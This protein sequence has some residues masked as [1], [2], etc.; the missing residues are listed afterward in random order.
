MPG[1]V[2]WHGLGRH[3]LGGPVEIEFSVDLPR[4]Q[5]RRPLMLKVDG[6]RSIGVILGDPAAEDSSAIGNA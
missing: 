1:K 5:E 6:R 2:V 3:R 4:E